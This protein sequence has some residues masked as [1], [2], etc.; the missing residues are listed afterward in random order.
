LITFSPLSDD[1]ILTFAKTLSSQGIIQQDNHYCYLKL[2]DCYI[3][4]IQPMLK[5]FGDVVKPPY[6]EPPY[7]VGTHISIIY[8]EEQAPVPSTCVGQLHT[9]EVQAL[10]KARYDFREQY[11]LLV[12]A[13]TLSQFRETHALAPN[14]TFKGQR[15]QFHIT[16]G[17]KHPTK[18]THD[19]P[20]NRN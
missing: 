20:P 15:I 7:D 13:P 12:T 14:P 10:V 11:I 6:F 5:R 8:P 9:F 2:D 17:V 1:G 18:Y 3:N 19:E 16:L 4:S